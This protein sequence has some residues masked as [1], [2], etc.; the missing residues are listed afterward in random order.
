[1]NLDNFFPGGGGRL[2]HFGYMALIDYWHWIYPH[3]FALFPICVGI[4][5]ACTSILFTTSFCTI[6]TY[7]YIIFTL[8]LK[9]S[10]LKPPHAYNKRWP[11]CLD[12]SCKLPTP[13]WEIMNSCGTR[14]RTSEYEGGPTVFTYL[15]PRLM[16]VL[17]SFHQSIVD[18]SIYPRSKAIG[19]AQKF[20]D[21]SLRTTLCPSSSLSLSLSLSL[22]RPTCLLGC[23]FA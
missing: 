19:R 11:P 7:M 9:T 14:A 2:T 20:I 6:Y 3:L 4:Y 23:S 13:N 15:F 17:G 22:F 21:H 1:M 18:L 16:L 5:H 8:V 12:R 10:L